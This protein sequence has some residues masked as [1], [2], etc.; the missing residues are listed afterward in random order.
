M[1]DFGKGWMSSNAA[2]LCKIMLVFGNVSIKDLLRELRTQQGPGIL[3]VRSV[4]AA[5]ARLRNE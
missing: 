1:K 4:E 2:D 3:N 5:L